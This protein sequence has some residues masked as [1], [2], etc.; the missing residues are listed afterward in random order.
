MESFLI[1]FRYKDEIWFHKILKGKRCQ[2]N[3]ITH[4]APYSHEVQHLSVSALTAVFLKVMLPLQ[5]ENSMIAPKDTISDPT[6]IV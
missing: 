1:K 6:N 2:K 5:P 4:Y 3:K